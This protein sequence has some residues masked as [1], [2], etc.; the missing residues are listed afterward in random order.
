MIA[1]T[2]KLEIGPQNRN[3][4]ANRKESCPAPLMAGQL[5]SV[6]WIFIVGDKNRHA[7]VQRSFY[8]RV[9]AAD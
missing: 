4:T 5:S 8:I 1:H 3:K 2:S 7:I 6:F 9:Q